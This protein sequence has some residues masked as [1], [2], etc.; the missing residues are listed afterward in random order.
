MAAGT[1]IWLSTSPDPTI[2]PTATHIPADNLL[3]PP[4][5]T[6]AD[7][8]AIENLAAELTA[9]EPMLDVFDGELQI[10]LRLEQALSNIEVVRPEDR[11]LIYRVLLFQGLAVSRYFQDGLATEDGAESYRTV[12]IRAVEVRPWIDAIAFDSQREP[13][14]EEI[15]EE[16][17]LLKFQE[18]RAR[19]LLR[20][21]TPISAEVPA[22]TRL[23][24][25][26][27]EAVGDAVQ[28]LPGRHWVSLTIDGMPVA[29]T[30][31]LTEK[32]GPFD[33]QR[34][35]LWPD[36]A[37]LTEGMSS[38]SASIALSA[39]TQAALASLESPVVL[40]TGEGRMQQAYMVSGAHATPWLDTEPREAKLGW[41]LSV[42]SGWLYDGD[43]YLQNAR[44]GAPE[45]VS[46]VNAIAPLLS[47]GLEWR[48]GVPVVGVGIDTLLPTGEWHDLPTGDT[49]IRVRPYPHLAAGVENLQV[50][51]G[52][53]LPWHIGVGP[54]AHVTLIESLGLTLTGAYAYGVPVSRS[55]EDG[56]IFTPEASQTGW[57]SVGVSR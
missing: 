36:L 38:G 33:F 40:Y 39:A 2:D 14:L 31:V 32:S 37:A 53:L 45:E 30:K 10:M 51:A 4:A 54:R 35:L 16:P 29:H 15:P 21:T 3:P 22:G 49:R 43:F 1:G 48:L 26:G 41:R 7:A 9:V 8:R 25:N 34:P 20:T 23:V 56:S 44:A 52:L 42:G 5:W 6:E 19:H 24:I 47:A 11:D 28:V 57:L 27:Q 46:T 55:H 13:G 50:T 18:V 17:E 12:L